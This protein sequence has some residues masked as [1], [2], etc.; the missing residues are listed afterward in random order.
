[1][2]NFNLIKKVIP[3]AQIVKIN[4]QAKIQLGIFN[5]EIEAK[6]Q[7]QKLQSKG[8]KIYIQPTNN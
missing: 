4:Q 2:D 7:G 1:M 6:N 3:N 5:S 8:I